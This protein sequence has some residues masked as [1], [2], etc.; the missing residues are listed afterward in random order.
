MKKFLL[1]TTAM[2]ALGAAPVFAAT[3]AKATAGST[4]ATVK[5]SSDKAVKKAGAPKAK[6]HKAMI[7][8]AS[9]KS[10]HIGSRKSLDAKERPITA[11]LNK[12]S[13]AAAGVAGATVAGQPL[14]NQ[15]RQ[16]QMGMSAQPMATGA[17]PTTGLRPQDPT[18]GTQ[19]SPRQPGNTGPG[20]QQGNPQNPTP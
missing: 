9:A 7:H 13:Q 12:E 16:P 20:N 3:D 10:V 6:A 15:S 5:V 1:I 19:A 18:A 8:S 11:Q 14:L 2:V 4:S 17:A